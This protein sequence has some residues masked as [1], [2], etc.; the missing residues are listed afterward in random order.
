MLI[1]YTCLF[2]SFNFFNFFLRYVTCGYDLNIYFDQ[3]FAATVQI[4]V[5]ELK[6]RLLNLCDFDEKMDFYY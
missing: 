6:C 4:P 5:L 3:L 1:A 2:D